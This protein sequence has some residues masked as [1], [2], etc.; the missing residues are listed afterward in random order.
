MP[1]ASLSALPSAAAL[2]QVWRVDE[3]AA[4]ETCSA[5]FTFDGMARAGFQGAGQPAMAALGHE[6]PFVRETA[7]IAVAVT[8]PEGFVEALYALADDAEGKTRT[9]TTIVGDTDLPQEVVD[10]IINASQR[11]IFPAA[12]SERTVS[13]SGL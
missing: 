6:D 5:A 10:C 8:R 3:L 4:G 11:W 1:P 7:A 9:K 12:M 2:T 13:I